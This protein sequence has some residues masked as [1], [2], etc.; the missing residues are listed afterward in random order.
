MAL[1]NGFVTYL[2]SSPTS[3]VHTNE[4]VE[5][6]CVGTQ[7]RALKGLKYPLSLTSHLSRSITIDHH[8]I[9]LHCWF[10][11]SILH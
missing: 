7:P 11:I 8:V 2:F 9:N 1:K 4:S 5:G 6:D 10:A 3:D